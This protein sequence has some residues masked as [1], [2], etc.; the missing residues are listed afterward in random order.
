MPRR[1]VADLPAKTQ[2][3]PDQGYYSSQWQ[4]WDGWEQGWTPSRDDWSQKLGDERQLH[5]KGAMVEPTDEG[6]PWYGHQ[7]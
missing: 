6:D 7:K 5:I 4:G 3:P 1:S 2:T